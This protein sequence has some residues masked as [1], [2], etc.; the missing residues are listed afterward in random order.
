M[1]FETS[2]TNSANVNTSSWYWRS[3]K[4]S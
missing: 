1:Y 3:G 2:L 4:T